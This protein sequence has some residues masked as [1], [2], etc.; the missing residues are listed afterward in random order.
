MA[1]K[2]LSDVLT[3]ET[4]ASLA[5]GESFGRGRRYFEQ[6][7]VKALKES[8][9]V[10]T[11][12]VRGSRWYTVELRAE[13]VGLRGRCSCPVGEDGLFC[14]HCVAT[15]LAWIT[16]EE[17][18]KS[19]E[20]VSASPEAVR[21]Y[22]GG[23]SREKLVELVMAQ[24]QTDERLRQQ[25]V[26]AVARTRPEGPDVQAIRLAID[27]ATRSGEAWSEQRD[28]NRIE[29]LNA[30]LDTLDELLK[31]GS[32]QAVAELAAFGLERADSIAGKMYRPG[33]EVEQVVSRFVSQHVRACA[34]SGQDPEKLARWLFEFEL[35]SDNA[36][37]DGV[38]ARYVGLLGENGLAAY[39]RLAVAEWRARAVKPG[40]PRL[41]GTYR[42]REI[43]RHAALLTVDPRL[44]VEVGKHDTGVMWA[45]LSA[46]QECTDMGQPD[47]AV[48]W[49]E[50]GLSSSAA[51]TAYELHELLADE[52]VRRGAL[53]EA[54]NHAW[55]AFTERP[56]VESYLRLRDAAR[57]AKQAA[58][59]REEALEYLRERSVRGRKTGVAEIEAEERKACASLIVEIQLKEKNVDAAWREASAGDCD[60]KVWMKLAKAREAGHPADAIRVYQQS[61]E[62]AIQ[63]GTSHAYEEAVKYLRRARE[64]ATRLGYPEKFL[65]YLSGLRERY[66]RKKKLLWLLDREFGS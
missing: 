6:G 7:R 10:I 63:V 41:A 56:R 34:E 44:M 3:K 39:R 40:Q 62:R 33:A 50:A 65:E 60:T 17:L 48:A 24:A 58:V 1:G 19:P 16:S 23:L 14:K 59:W 27:D 61:A 38:Y 45:Y 13:P 9:G 31:T 32:A 37:H 11:A 28:A 26:L 47:K 29:K 42:V 18:S 43:A 20:S 2:S 66:K 30:V 51:G 8:D 53:T 35:S 36:T 12:R 55:A 64:V 5:Y 54:L 52:Y 15:G 49:A 4:L 25:L 22:L 21:A 46:A 57:K